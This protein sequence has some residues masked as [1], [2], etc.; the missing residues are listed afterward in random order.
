MYPV[1]GA[2]ASRGGAAGVEIRT[3]REIGT[4]GVSVMTNHAQQ[5]ISEGD[6]VDR[7]GFLKCMAWA[8]TG[9]LWTAGGGILSSRAFG[10]DAGQAGAGNFSFVQ[11]S[12]SHIGFGKDP[13]KKSVTA[14]LQAAVAQI[15]ALPKRPRL[16]RSDTGDPCCTSRRLPQ[17]AR[18][19]S[20]RRS[21]RRSG[22]ERSST[23]QASTM[24]FPTA[25]ST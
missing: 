23:C 10:Q 18:H 2:D 4:R 8:G 17:R 15:N 16:P 3:C 11:I 13:Y 9:V 12:D 20:P 1:R 14:T 19:P 21:S 22:S 5:Q 7:R 6:G 24:S 25:R